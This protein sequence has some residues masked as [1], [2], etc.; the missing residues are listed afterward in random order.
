MYIQITTRCNMSCEHCCMAATARGDDMSEDVFRA[1]LKIAEEYGDIV[2]LGGGEPTLHS[3][4]KDFL[5]LA[6]AAD[7]ESDPFVITNG[8]NTE[9]S[10]ILAKLA[11]KGAIGAALSLDEYH[12]DINW[13]VREAFLKRPSKWT[14]GDND[15]RGIHS[16]NRII[17]Q[18][19]AKDRGEAGCA[20][21]D[22]YLTP[23]GDI[24][25]CLC[26]TKRFGTVFEPSIPDEWQYGVC[27]KEQ[28][29]FEKA[30]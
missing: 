10:L 8:S 9:T 6:I 15:L 17:A 20:C 12:D 22:I 30:A 14:S 18:G 1:A 28:E 11:K 13:A 7:L 27:A 5:L 2:T 26:K 21:E 25:G 19:R 24:Y 16:A 23:R 4:F 3:R 29:E